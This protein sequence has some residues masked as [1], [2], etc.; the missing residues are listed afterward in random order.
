MDMSTCSRRKKQ[1]KNI[2]EIRLIILTE[3]PKQFFV[4]LI[5]YILVN[6]FFSYVRTGL[7]G[8]N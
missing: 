8:L 4:C 7:L 3:I 6:N 1:D 2:T 5:L